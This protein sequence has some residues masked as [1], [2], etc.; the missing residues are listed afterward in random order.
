[1]AA[2]KRSQNKCKKCG[3]TWYPRGKHI[4]LKCP[5]C[6]SSEVG[7]AGT[8]IGVFALIVIAVMV[9]NANKKETPTQVLSASPAPAEVSAVVGRQAVQLD[10]V[11]EQKVAPIERGDAPVYSGKVDDHVE[12]SLATSECVVGN[13]GKPIECSTADCATSTSGP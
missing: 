3:Y 13:E 6:G 1:M 9:F 4:S 10:L 2:T 12:T 5:S 11:S 7:Y 8:G